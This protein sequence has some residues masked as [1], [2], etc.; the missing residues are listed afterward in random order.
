MDALLKE[1]LPPTNPRT[2]ISPLEVH[3]VSSFDPLEKEKRLSFPNTLWYP[4]FFSYKTV[5]FD[6]LLNNLDVQEAIKTYPE[7]YKKIFYD[8]DLLLDI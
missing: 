3:S 4:G 7:K 8:R 1:L 5:E 6:R 2:K